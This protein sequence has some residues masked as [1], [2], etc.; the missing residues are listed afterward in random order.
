MACLSDAVEIMGRH[1]RSFCSLCLVMRTHHRVLSA[2][3]HRKQGLKHGAKIVL[4]GEA[5]C[6]DPSVQPGDVV[7]VLDQ[8]EHRF[9][10]RINQVPCW[11]RWWSLVSVW[12][13]RS[14]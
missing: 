10:K 6:S 13:S 14:R 9:F 2:V 5:G 3:R 12:T 1:E 11:C 7:F 8:K 4:R